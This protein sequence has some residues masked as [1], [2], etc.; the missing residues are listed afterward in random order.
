MARTVLRI[1][2]RLNRGGPLRQLCAL[3]PGLSRL[4]WSGPILS[5]RVAPGESDASPDLQAVGG[6]VVRVQGLQRGLEPLRDTQALRAIL[7]AVRQYQPDLIHTHL[8]KA[9]ALG[10]VAARIAGVPVIHTVHGHHL[11]SAPAKALGVRWSERLLG[12]LTDAVIALSAR[13]ARD[14]VEVHRVL[15]AQRVHVIPP[16]MDLAG[17]R[18]SA[19]AG[20]GPHVLLRDDAPHFLWTGRHVPVKDPLLLVEAVARA[21]VPYHLTML[22]RGPLL[23]S[24]RAAVRAKGLEKRISCPG[25]VRNVAPWLRAADALVLCSRSEGTPLSVI[26]AMALGKPVVVTTV[27]GVP[28]MVA[29]QGTGLWV[30][31]RAPQALAAAL[32]RLASDPALGRRLGLAARSVVD[33]RFGA[34]RLARDTAA[35]YDEVLRGSV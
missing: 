15:P 2:T 8:A 21:Q 23:A 1:I 12:R 33:E 9:G 35:L 13:Q 28:D 19:E 5:G 3:V 22:G 20:L 6:D 29:H 34:E 27:G 32:D 18:E 7:A 31:P 16:G 30:P 4:G 17:F 25:S 11:E 14:L 26:E 10:R 24:V